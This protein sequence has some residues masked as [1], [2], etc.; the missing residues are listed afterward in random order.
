MVWRTVRA[1]LQLDTSL[2]ANQIIPYIFL[3]MLNNAID[4]SQGTEVEITSSI[5]DKQWSFAIRDNGIGAFRNLKSHFG[6]TSDIEAIA[7]L[8]KGKQTTDPTKHSGEA[9]SFHPN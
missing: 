1:E 2:A 5:S 3:E 7:E 6:L 8:S 4:H 9:S